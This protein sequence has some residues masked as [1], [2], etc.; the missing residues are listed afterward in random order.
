MDGHSEYITSCL[1]RNANPQKDV[2]VRKKKKLNA[3]NDQCLEHSCLLM[4]NTHGTSQVE[5]KLIEK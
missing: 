4:E 3:P 5:I 1:L 2:E